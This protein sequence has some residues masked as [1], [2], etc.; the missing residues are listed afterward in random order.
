MWRF[1]TGVE[2]PKNKAKSEEENRESKKLYD[3]FTFGLK[4]R[5]GLSEKERCIPLSVYF[6]ALLLRT[7][8][9]FYIIRKFDLNI[10]YKCIH[11]SR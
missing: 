2:P 10:L 1:V 4:T 11:I 8:K 6:S 3:T 9:W 7:R 5:E